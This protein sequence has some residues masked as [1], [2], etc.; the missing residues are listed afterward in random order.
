MWKQVFDYAKEIV[1]L[2]RE[3]QENKSD[4]KELKTEIRELRAEVKQLRADF[5]NLVLLVQQFS[6]D[7]QNVSKREKAERKNLA[8]QLENEML[9][10]ERRLPQGKDSEK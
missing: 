3:T 6:F 7:I 4:I 8:L 2:S 9:K 1:F 10:F 5:N